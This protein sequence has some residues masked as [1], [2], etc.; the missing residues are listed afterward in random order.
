MSVILAVA[1][2]PDDETLGCGGSLLRHRTEGDEIH[3][4]IMTTIS[5]E[6][7]F[8][9]KRVNSRKGEIASVADTYGFNSVHQTKFITSQL[10]TLAKSVLIDE[11]SSIINKVK[12]DTIYLPFRN[13]IHS[14]HTTVFDAV[15]A[16]TKSFRYP[17]I[18]R[19]RAYETL[20]E[21]EFAIRPD[22]VGFKPN[23]WID[24]ADYLDEKL[25][26]MQIYKGEMDAHPF[27]RSEKNIRALATL[28]GATV[29][30]KAAESFVTL[31]EIL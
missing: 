12:P 16:C 17:F 18:Q 15:A 14:D 11:V 13:D 7:G 29:G 19:V 2:H 26:I 31:K 10:D 23:L 24:I 27:P 6:A 9:I 8:N 30:R 28:R 25:K 4:L 22:P 5:V 21:T 3:W 1:A 20:S